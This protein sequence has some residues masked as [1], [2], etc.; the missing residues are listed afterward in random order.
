[1]DQLTPAQRATLDCVLDEI[2]PPSADGRMP[3]AGSLGLAAGV[4]AMLARNPGAVAALGEALAAL[5]GQGE[6]RFSALA[7][8]QRLAALNEFTARNPGFVPGLLFATYARYYQEPRV[9]EAL[10]LEARPPHP[11]GHVLEPG[12]WSLLDAVRRRGKIYRD[13]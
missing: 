8:P 2:V 4:E 9:L 7:P 10:G 13:C 3:G 5:E 6:A 12:D 11:G 1:M